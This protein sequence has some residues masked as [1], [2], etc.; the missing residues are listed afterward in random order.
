MPLWVNWAYLARK[1]LISSWTS[2]WSFGIRQSR[3]E[4]SMR[5][6]MRAINIKYIITPA[7]MDAKCCAS[8][9][10]YKMM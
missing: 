4:P 7:D 10:A 5:L 8:K 1:K 6:G 9:W 3:S 2:S